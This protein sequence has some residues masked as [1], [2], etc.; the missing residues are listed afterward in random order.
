MFIQLVSL[1]YFHTLV[2]INV[3]TA[4]VI[5]F[6][7][8]MRISNQTRDVYWDL[9]FSCGWKRERGRVEKGGVAFLIESDPSSIFETFEIQEYKLCV[10]G[11]DVVDIGAGFGESSIYFA[12]K[13]ASKVYAFEPVPARC[14]IAK[15]NFALNPLIS[16]RIKLKQIAV[17]ASPELRVSGKAKMESVS[18]PAKASLTEI[19][20]EV[21]D[22]FLLKID[23]EGCEYDLITQEFQSVSRFQNVIFEFHPN[24]TFQSPKPLFE[25]FAQVYECHLSQ[26]DKMLGVMRCTKK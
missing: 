4:G 5:Q 16:D 25:L 19:I 20:S 23:C 12:H 13:G 26:A 15:R 22:P 21:E 17:V 10:T 9:L 24:M 7:R 6:E 14:A 8:G 2:P 11:H 1:S 3:D 18:E